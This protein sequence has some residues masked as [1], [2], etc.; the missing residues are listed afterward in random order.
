MK[1]FHEDHGS[2]FNVLGMAFSSTYIAI[3]PISDQAKQYWK[4]IGGGEAI[5]ATFRKNAGMDHIT[6]IRW[7][8]MSYHEVEGEVPHEWRGE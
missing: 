5:S 7:E 8:G 6:Q 4:L 3:A 1:E 2:D